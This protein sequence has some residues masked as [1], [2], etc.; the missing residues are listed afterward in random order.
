MKQWC[1]ILKHLTGWVVWVIR[2]VWSWFINLTFSS[3]EIKQTIQNS[4]LLAMGVLKVKALICKK[5]EVYCCLFTSLMTQKM[6]E[7]TRSLDFFPSTSKQNLPL[8]F[9][10]ILLIKSLSKYS[11]L[12]P[13]QNDRKLDTAPRGGKLILHWNIMNYIRPLIL[14]TPSIHQYFSLLMG[15]LLLIALIE[16]YLLTIPFNNINSICSL[17]HTL[18]HVG[19]GN[20]IS[21]CII[22]FSVRRWKPAQNS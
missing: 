17:H 13:S 6:G 3:K 9:L 7:L 21:F 12:N 18:K 19:S 20:V 16:G 8:S 4:L 1:H 22:I 10:I 5:A 2:K 14:W 15:V 11:I